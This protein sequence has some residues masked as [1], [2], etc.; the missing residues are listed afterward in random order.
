[1]PR[2]DV[3]TDDQRRERLGNLFSTLSSPG[4]SPDVQDVP[5][6]SK[7]FAMPESDALA[8]ARAFLPLLAASNADL[9][10]RQAAGED[11]AIDAALGG[12]GD[13]KGPGAARAKDKDEDEDEDE[14]GDD[15][16]DGAGEEGGEK[17]EGEDKGGQTHVEMDVG[18]GVFDVKGSVVGD[19]GPVVERDA[20]VWEGTAGKRKA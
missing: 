6:P 20:A 8:R 3:E 7:P 1:M 12:V 16:E 5:F 14:A 19:V 18:V 2:L 13:T 17:G 15:D 4:S 10:A 11:V 9:V